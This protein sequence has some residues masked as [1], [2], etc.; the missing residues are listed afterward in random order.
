[1]A[2]WK[3]YKMVLDVLVT[4][5][6]ADELPTTQMMEEAMKDSLTEMAETLEENLT[7]DEGAVRMNLKSVQ[8]LVPPDAPAYDPSDPVN[9]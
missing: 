9:R 6:D 2:A 5:D 4:A 1:M 3:T 8:E 7:V